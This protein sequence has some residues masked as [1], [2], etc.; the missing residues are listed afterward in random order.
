MFL[1]SVS[2]RTCAKSRMKATLHKKRNDGM[3]ECELEA[4]VAKKAKFSRNMKLCDF[5]LHVIVQTIEDQLLGDS[6]VK[7]RT[8]GALRLREYMTLH[9]RKRRMLKVDNFCRIDV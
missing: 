7:F 1:D 3:A 2:Q 8:Q 9:S 5:H 4:S 6:R